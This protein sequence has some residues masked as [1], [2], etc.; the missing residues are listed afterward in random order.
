MNVSDGRSKKIIG[1]KMG[2]SLR[3]TIPGMA[4]H[5]MARGNERQS[6]FRDKQN[7]VCVY[8]NISVEVLTGKKWKWNTAKRVLIY[9]LV[10]DAGIRNPEIARRLNGL[11]SSGIGKIRDK[12]GV[13]LGKTRN[14]KRELNRL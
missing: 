12:I 5:V 6:I 4:Y 8:H 2:H 14:L 1:A 9:L 7:A 3:I 10:K 13:E 11:H